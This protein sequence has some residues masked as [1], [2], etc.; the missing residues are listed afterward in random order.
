MVA[1]EQPPRETPSL[2]P[3]IALD[4]H[5]SGARRQCGVSAQLD[6]ISLQSQYLVNL[7]TGLVENVLLEEDTHSEFRLA[8]V[9]SLTRDGAN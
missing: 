5:N 7:S 4:A 9:A 2:L 8:G 3:A 6:S 1:G